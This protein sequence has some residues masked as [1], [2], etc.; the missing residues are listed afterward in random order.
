MREKNLWE[1]ANCRIIML[2]KE[3][4]EEKGLNKNQHNVVEKIN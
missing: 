2:A 4:Q 3:M 1:E